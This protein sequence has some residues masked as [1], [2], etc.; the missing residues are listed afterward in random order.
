MSQSARSMWEEF[1]FQY[2][3]PGLTGD[4]GGKCMLFLNYYT[5]KHLR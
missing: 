1:R 3:I 4:D 2:E 5:K